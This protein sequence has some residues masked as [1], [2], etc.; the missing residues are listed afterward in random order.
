MQPP[1]EVETKWVWS[2]APP[3]YSNGDAICAAFSVHTHGAF[4]AVKSD[5]KRGHS[6]A[7]A[8]SRSIRARE[9]KED[10]F[11]R[12]GMS[13]EATLGQESGSFAHTTGKKRSQ[14][15]RNEQRPALINDQLQ[16]ARELL[17]CEFQSAARKCFSPLKTWSKMGSKLKCSIIN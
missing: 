17:R 10:K 15:S 3:S 7:C 4:F 11:A 1:V 5:R 2:L 16:P 6:H 8:Y 13:A 14:R 12:C 9:Y